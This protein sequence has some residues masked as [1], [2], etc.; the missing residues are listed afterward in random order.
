MLFFL[1]CEKHPQCSTL[2]TTKTY[3]VWR[4][5]K[6]CAKYTISNWPK[7]ICNK[8]VM[9]YWINTVSIQHRKKRHNM[10]MI[11]I[12]I[13]ITKLKNKK[14]YL[15]WIVSSEHR[16]AQWKTSTAYYSKCQKSV[17]RNEQHLEVCTIQKQHQ[18]AAI[19]ECKSL[20]ILYGCECY[21]T[22]VIESQFINHSSFLPHSSD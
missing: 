10:R 21:K 22:I 14:I 1:T 7:N 11:Q 20:T 12:F 18:A 19:L 17:L 9:E 2:I 8:I 4:I 16:V 5:K 15:A 13:F 6:I 3:I